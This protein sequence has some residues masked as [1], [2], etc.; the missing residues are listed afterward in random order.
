MKLRTLVASMGL[1]AGL[2]ASPAFAATNGTTSAQTMDQ[3]KARANKM[4]Q[5]LTKG[6]ILADHPYLA[7]NWTDR[8][9]LS[10][11]INV[12]FKY[13]TANGINSD[14]SAYASNGYNRT[15]FNKNSSSDIYLNN[16]QIDLDAKVNDWTNAHISLTGKDPEDLVYRKKNRDNNSSDGNNI[17]LDEAYI[18]FGN[19]DHAP[20]YATVGRQYVPFGV[21]DR[22]PLEP[23][24]TQYL[25]ETQATAAKLGFVT[26][27][28]YGSAF[29]FRG[30]SHDSANN[31]VDRNIDNWGA[32]I[33]Y[34]WSDDVWGI[35]L[36]AGY[37]NNMVDV[38][39]I[40][41][42]IATNAGGTYNTT[43]TYKDDVSAASAHAKVSYGPFAIRGDYVTA[44]SS[45]G[46]TSNI[47]YKGKGAE[48]WA[49]S[50]EASF[51]FPLMDRDSTIA[52]NY[53]R[54]GEAVAIGVPEQRY[55]ASY[56]IDV[57]KDTS[58]QFLVLRDSDYGKGSGGTGRN[59]TEGAMRVSVNF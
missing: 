35:N 36:D 53:Q 22:H 52:I 2:A 7:D 50:T 49:A 58:L 23:T 4:E 8:I 29:A 18:T 45:F 19:L 20:F 48:P 51:S 47:T 41:A 37:L 55:G 40:D 16:S 34:T 25:T 46:N 12:D 44:L 56:T 6:S 31:D 11:Q 30:R 21:Y 3:T 38:D 33:G 57:L 54:S 59:A 43:N 15:L 42:S 24:L 9:R 39:A 14:G 26:G 27:G 10:G 5:V 28:F 32:N 13:R 1:A 17:K